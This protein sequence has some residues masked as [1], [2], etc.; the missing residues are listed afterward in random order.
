MNIQVTDYLWLNDTDERADYCVWSGENINGPH[1]R[2]I[3]QK[4]SN[5]GSVAFI[6]IE[7]VE[8]LADAINQHYSNEN[9]SQYEITPLVY[10]MNE[11]VLDSYTD[12][13]E[14][15]HCIICERHCEGDVYKVG[16][17]LIHVECIEE[18]VQ[19]LKEDV[20]EY[21]DEILSEGFSE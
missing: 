9:H 3:S 10:Y 7:H 16:R 4:G 21:S 6:C 19:I 1:V 18:F 20:W 12:G 17:A 8:A 2:I 14:R 15:N 13:P 11:N 5:I